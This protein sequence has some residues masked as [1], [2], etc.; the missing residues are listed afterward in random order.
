M[1]FDFNSMNRKTF[2]FF[3]MF[4]D[5]SFKSP[6]RYFAN[7][8]NTMYVVI[9]FSWT[10]SSKNSDITLE[11][12]SRWIKWTV[13]VFVGKEFSMSS[14][15]LGTEGYSVCVCVSSSLS[16]SL[17]ICTLIYTQYIFSIFCI[18]IISYLVSI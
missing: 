14:T 4:Q 5:S 8:P 13:I 6:F 16:R 9:V 10:Y 2:L 18:W 7:M 1:D 12:I 15:A 17:S 11:Q 3:G